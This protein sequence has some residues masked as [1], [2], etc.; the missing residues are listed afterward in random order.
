MKSLKATHGITNRQ[1]QTQMLTKK[2]M[3]SP[4]P[5]INVEILG[6]SAAEARTTRLAVSETAVLSIGAD[7]SGI[8]QPLTSIVDGSGLHHD[9]IGSGA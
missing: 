3:A 5:V 4:A 6:R 7:W 2:R 1:S 8:L 9:Q